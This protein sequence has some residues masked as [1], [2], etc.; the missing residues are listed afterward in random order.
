M[1][2][3]NTDREHAFTVEPGMRIAQLVV[4]PIAAVEAGRDARA[5]RQRA[6]R[7]AA[8]ARRGSVEAA[9][10]PEPRVR[11]SAILRWHDRILLCRHEKRGAEHW[12]LPGGGVRSGESLTQA[13]LARARRGDGA[14]RGRRRAAGRGPGRDRRLDLAGAQPLV[15]ARRPH[16][17]RGRARRLAR[18]GRL[19][20]RGGARPPAVRPDELDGIALHPPI[21]R[22][23][24]RWQP[25]DPCVYL[26]SLWA[27]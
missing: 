21:R 5:N 7:S 17:L 10:R 23:L 6:R 14:D 25:G 27:P 12:L 4:V 13:L 16:R 26:G 15:E 11:V 2:L 3:L 18:R 8:S 20:R 1:I 22:F 24:R 9:M 19:P